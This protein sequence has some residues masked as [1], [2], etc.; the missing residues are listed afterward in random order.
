MQ[1]PTSPSSHSTKHRSP[2]LSY[3]QPTTTMEER[4]DPRR[5]SQLSQRKLR[6]ASCD[7]RRDNHNLRRLVLT[8]NLL[9]SAR[10]KSDA[11]LS[12]TS[13]SSSS[14]SQSSMETEPQSSGIQRTEEPMSNRDDDYSFGLVF[15]DSSSWETQDGETL[16]GVDES[17]WLDA[18]LSY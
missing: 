2:R 6:C 5:I 8:Q 7:E 12:S 11:S 10:N 15:P 1:Y 13:T 16:T 18:V 17:K 14:S 4:I 3:P 9:L